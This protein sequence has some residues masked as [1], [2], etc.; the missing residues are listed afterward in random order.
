MSAEISLSEQTSSSS[1][2]TILLVD[3]DRFLIDMYSMKFT[4]S[5]YQVHA[6][7][8]AKDALEVLR[9]GYKADAI[10]LDLLMPEQDGFSFLQELSTEPN[11]K[12]AALIAL[13]N[14]GND[15]D[16]VKAEQMGVDRY[17]VKAS[18]IPSEVVSAV[19]EEIL[20]KKGAK[21]Q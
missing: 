20:K 5:G 17:I 21:P 7:L 9:G 10:L 18:M 3:D 16:K 1:K 14:Q 19:G 2:G 15:A 8:S 11:A 4:G 13:T 6:S 12:G